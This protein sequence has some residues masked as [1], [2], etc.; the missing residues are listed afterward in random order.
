MKAIQIQFG[1]GPYDYPMETLLKLKQDGTLE[2]YK[3]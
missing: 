3:N 1:R 2:D